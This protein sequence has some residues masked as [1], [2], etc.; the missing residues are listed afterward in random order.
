MRRTKSILATLTLSAVALVGATAVAAV[1]GP[2]GI[3][4][5]YSPSR[6]RSL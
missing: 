4:H 5:G 2:A 1:A 6:S 3:R